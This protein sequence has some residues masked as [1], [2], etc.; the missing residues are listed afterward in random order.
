[1]F[2]LAKSTSNYRAKLIYS[3]YK[4]WLKAGDKVL[5]IGCGNGII[6]YFLH[7]KLKIDITCCDVK[8]Y[9]IYKFPFYKITGSK[10]PFKNKQFDLV[11]INDVL[12][13]IESDK[14]LAVISEALRVGK[15]VLIFEAKPTFSGKMFDIILN[16][17]HYGGLDQP[18]SFRNIADWE[19]IFKKLGVNYKYIELSRPFW[20]PFSHVAFKLWKK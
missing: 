3:A 1:M 13:H 6:A 2:N 8:N 14:H 16:K 15:V 20:Y 4:K 7:N 9:L 19:T 11:F 18:L 17:F 12:H 10:L 5:D